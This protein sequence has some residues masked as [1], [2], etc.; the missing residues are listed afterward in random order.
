PQPFRVES[1]LRKPWLDA[2]LLRD[3]VS[4]VSLRQSARTLGVALGTV[5]DRI[6][7]LGLHFLLAR[8]NALRGFEPRG[9]FQF[10]EIETFEGDRR[11]CPLTVGLLVSGSS[12]LLVTS[13]VG[14]MRSRAGASAKSKERRA[15]YE[16][17][18]G[19]RPNESRRVV[20]V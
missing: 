2:A 19:R 20:E 3:F 16:A 1:G 14:R 12:G 8:E 9:N 5:E 4:G 15:R 17:R 13:G 6:D 10:D 7:R 18:E 11:L